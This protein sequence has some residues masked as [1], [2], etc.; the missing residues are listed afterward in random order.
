[1]FRLLPLIMIAA[2][3]TGCVSQTNDAKPETPEPEAAAPTNGVPE[4]TQ[5]EKEETPLE[6][7]RNDIA[8]LNAKAEHKADEI[9]VQHLL[10]AHNQAGI[11][12]VTRSV[13]EAEQLTAELWQKVKEGADFDALV[14]EHTNDSH[15]GI[16]GMTVRGPGDRNR[17][18]FPR[19]GMVAAFGNVGW[20]LEVGEYGVAGYNRQTSPYGWHIIKRTR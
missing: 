5:P 6:T 20:R 12:G 19:T 14:K 9:E 8:E 17:N 1:M 13:E 2:L 3:A 11:P 10:I 18:V 15:P 16:Y 7:L 4:T